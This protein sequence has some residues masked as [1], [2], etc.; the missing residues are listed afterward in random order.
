VCGCMWRRPRQGTGRER[1]S[2]VAV[3]LLFSKEVIFMFVLSRDMALVFAGPSLRDRRT[4]CQP[5]IG[6]SSELC[7]DRSERGA[8]PSMPSQ[9]RG[10]SRWL[11][12]RRCWRT[13]GTRYQLAATPAAASPGQCLD[14]SWRRPPSDPTQMSSSRSVRPGNG[15]GAR[16]TT[17]R[18]DSPCGQA[19]ASLSPQSSR[20]Q[21]RS[22][23]K[24]RPQPVPQ[25]RALPRGPE[26]AEEAHM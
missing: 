18:R 26:P 4:T 13:G 8:L 14:I 7:E 10:A 12:G 21:P 17:T 9:M 5:G 25:S 3:F 19:S 22:P 16:N 2:R 6:V 1:V 24:Q 11:P 20:K 23:P 15:P